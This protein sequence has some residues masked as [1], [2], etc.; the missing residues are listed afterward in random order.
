MAHGENEP[1]GHRDR[2]GGW[3]TTARYAAGYGVIA[4]LF[5]LATAV[6]S[7]FSARPSVWAT[8]LVLAFGLWLT[9]YGIAGRYATLR[10]GWIVAGVVAGVGAGALSM[11]LAEGMDLV[12][13]A[14]FPALRHS[15]LAFPPLRG[16][17]DQAALE[18]VKWLAIYAAL[19]GVLG[20][21]GALT[22]LVHRPS[23]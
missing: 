17:W 13:S 15:F 6:L 21:V 11:G 12:L 4:Y 19:G 2:T 7:E 14:V 5:R 22:V 1:L 20:A 18:G 3:A 10:S 23:A 9:T 16:A 8:L